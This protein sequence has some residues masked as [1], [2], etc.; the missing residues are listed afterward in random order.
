MTA[1]EPL[2]DL[3]RAILRKSEGPIAVRASDLALAQVL[4]RLG[5]SLAD[6]GARTLVLFDRLDPADP[7]SGDAEVDAAW[8][9]LPNDGVLILVSPNIDVRPDRGFHH[10]TLRKRL[11]RL[12][13]ASLLRNQ[14]FRWVGAV[15]AKGVTIDDDSRLRL[16]AVARECR[17]RVLELGSGNGHLGAAIA[18]RGLEVIGVELSRRK[19]AKAREYYPDLTF[20][21]GDIF[22]L[23]AGLEGFDT[24]VIAEVLEHVPAEAG[25]IMC[26]IARSRLREGGRLLVST[27]Y[28]DMVPHRNHLTEFTAAS[29]RDLL[30]RFG[31][32]RFCDHQ[33][34][35]WLLASV[36]VER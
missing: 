32:V 27:P 34:F 9:A 24:V 12:G 10:R 1:C 35:R 28:E 2:I 5:G 21:E 7:A 29:L 3:A 23:P 20:L 8:E 36:D 4:Q 22:K 18:A 16:A 6:K 11:D 30:G 33:P 19:V 15:L 17:G 31:E 26:D 14:P 13:T 25:S